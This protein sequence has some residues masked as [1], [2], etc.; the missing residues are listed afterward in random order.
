MTFESY[1]WS[2]TFL[3]SKFVTLQW[4]LEPDIISLMEIAFKEPFPK[5]WKIIQRLNN[6]VF[7]NDQKNDDDLDTKWPF[8]KE[9]VKYYKSLA[10]GKYGQCIIAYDG[11]KAVGY[12]AFAEKDFGYRKSK[13]VEIE[14]MGVD[15]N[16]RSQGIGKKLIDEIEKRAKKNGATKLYVS[17]YFKNK[18]A[19]SFYK[20]L[21][22]YETGLELDK[23]IR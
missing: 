2:H 22:F 6:Q 11:K 5:D 21:G 16:Y 8:S 19:I 20:S 14:N 4:T 10:S 13:Y 1:S 17:A 7:I 12:A 9:G 15:P 18:R 23:K 3:A